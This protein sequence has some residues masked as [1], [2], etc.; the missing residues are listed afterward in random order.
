MTKKKKKYA[1]VQDTIIY[2][3]IACILT[4]QPD[5]KIILVSHPDSFTWANI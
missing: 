5:N 3:H 1:V 2:E 4:R